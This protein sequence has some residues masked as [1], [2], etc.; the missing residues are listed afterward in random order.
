MILTIPHFIHPVLAPKNRLNISQSEAKIVKNLLSYT[1][2]RYYCTSPLE[3]KAGRCIPHLP[4]I[5]GKES[6]LTLFLPYHYL[7]SKVVDSDNVHTCTHFECRC[8]N[9]VHAQLASR[10]VIY[11]HAFCAVKSRNTDFVS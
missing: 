11:R 7:C 9:I 8:P 6:A 2:E 5:N 10:N 3:K 1:S 4:A